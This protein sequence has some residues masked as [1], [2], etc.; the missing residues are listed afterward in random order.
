MY[1]LRTSSICYPIRTYQCKTGGENQIDE[2]SPHP[3][4]ASLLDYSY[5]VGSPPAGLLLLQVPDRRS[6][7][8]TPY[9]LLGSCWWWWVSS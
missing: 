1:V 8:V 6:M 2:V 4:P 7:Y 9:P 5:G 3:S